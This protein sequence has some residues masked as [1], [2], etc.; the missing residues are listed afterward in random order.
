MVMEFPAYG[1]YE[2]VIWSNSNKGKIAALDSN[3]NTDVLSMHAQ[4]TQPVGERYQEEAEP[5]SA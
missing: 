4:S 1:D 2:R 5:A 3:G